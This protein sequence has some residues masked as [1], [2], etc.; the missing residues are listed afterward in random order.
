MKQ[1]QLSGY[2]FTPSERRLDLSGISGFDIR[3]LYA[4]A[5]LQAGTL[6]YALGLAGYRAT[7]QSGGVLSLEYDTTAMDANDPLFVLYEDGTLPLPIGAATDAKLETLRALLAGTLQVDGSGVTQPISATA[8]PLPG[9]AATEATLAAIKAAI[10]A[11]VDLETSVWTDGTSY[12]VRREV[13]AEG[14]GAITVSYTDP[15]GSVVTPPAG[16]RPVASDNAISLL[17]AYYDVKTAGTGYSLGD[18][19]ARIVAVNKAVSPP[20]A[21]SAIWLNMTTGAVIAAPP[22][23]NIAEQDQNTVVSSAQLPASLGRKTSSA[24]MSIA[25][26]SD[27]PVPVAIGVPTDAAATSDTGTFSIVSLIKRGLANWTTLLGR[28]PALNSGRVPVDGSG[29]TQPVSATSL[30]LPS[31]AATDATL[32]NVLAGIALLA[33]HA[34]EGA[35]LSKLEQM[36]ILLAAAA[37]DGTDPA[38]PAVANA[39]AG[40]RGWLAT[41]AGL[42]KLG[43]AA[44]AQSASMTIATDLAN[45]EPAGAAITA[46]A[47]P[48]GGAGLTGWLSAIWAALTTPASRSVLFADVTNASLGAGGGT[49]AVNHDAGASPNQWAKVNAFFFSSQPGNYTIQASNDAAFGNAVPVAS[50]AI[51]ASTGLPVSLPITFRYYR[52]FIVNGSTPASSVNLTMS[53]SAA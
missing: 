11:Q 19:V 38:S 7:S 47:M 39:G 17:T 10:L 53:F 50:G 45:L 24:S 2:V 51:A 9:G 44:K 34:D 4:V 42:L 52:A 27:D 5:N 28:I 13:V 8:L 40:I 18:I 46:A 14:T 33:T 23:A 30:P 6:I 49:A 12:Y 35:E 22:A 25:T 29:V 48:A 41:I 20:T 32:Q 37:Q 31:G 15:T 26:A 3:R 1:P 36:R 16:I 43:P 21:S